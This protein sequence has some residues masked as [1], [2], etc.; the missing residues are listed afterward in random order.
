MIEKAYTVRATI[1]QLS[2]VMEPELTTSMETVTLFSKGSVQRGIIFGLV[3]GGLM[4]VCITTMLCLLLGCATYQVMDGRR[5]PKHPRP[6]SA[7]TFPMR[8]P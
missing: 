4:G 1:A 3:T 5:V 7:A 2:Q 6:D 8:Q